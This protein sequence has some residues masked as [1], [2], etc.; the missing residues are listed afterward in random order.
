MKPLDKQ[1]SSKLARWR[2]QLQE[3]YPGLR[4]KD[5]DL[6]EWLIRRK[7][8]FLSLDDVVSIQRHFP[9]QIETGDSVTKDR[10]AAL[11]R[12]EEKKLRE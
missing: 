10:T 4:L 11:M 7:R 1:C 2:E 9:S 12:R 8:A 5:E 6:L 3:I